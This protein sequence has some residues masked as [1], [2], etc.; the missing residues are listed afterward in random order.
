MKWVGRVRHR[1]A[2]IIKGIAEGHSSPHVQL[3]WSQRGLSL[4]GGGFPMCLFPLGG[5]VRPWFPCS[6]ERRSLIDAF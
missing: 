3:L 6:G 2:C 1:W 4:G 5:S